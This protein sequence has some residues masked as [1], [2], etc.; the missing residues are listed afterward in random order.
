MKTKTAILIITGCIIL[1]LIGLG[2]TGYY[3]ENKKLTLEQIKNLSQEERK[4]Y[5]QKYGEKTL[6]VSVSENGFEPKVVEI[7]KGKSICFKNNSMDKT[8]VLIFSEFQ[9]R[10][11][12]H[13][14]WCRIFSKP[15]IFEYYLEGNPEIRGEVIVK[16]VIKQ[17]S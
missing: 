5:L 14:S 13:G 4:E 16:Q 9:S 15:G 10:E 7:D 6:Q 12:K 2:L 3:A 11:I 8:F 1:S 17:D